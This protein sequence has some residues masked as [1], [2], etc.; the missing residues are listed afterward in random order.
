MW[1]QGVFDPVADAAL[2]IAALSLCLTILWRQG[3]RLGAPRFPGAVGALWVVA[4]V[5]LPVPA[6]FACGR[7]LDRCDPV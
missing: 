7:A 3:R 1:S 6:Y 4:A 5:A 2:L